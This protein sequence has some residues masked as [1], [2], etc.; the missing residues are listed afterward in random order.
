MV[1]VGA[2]VVDVEALESAT[3][4]RP[5]PASTRIFS[6]DGLRVISS[7]ITLPL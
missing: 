3:I 7:P 1:D 5:I 2:A 4:A 6:T